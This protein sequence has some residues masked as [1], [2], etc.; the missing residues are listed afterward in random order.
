MLF[1]YKYANNSTVEST[2]RKTDMAFAPDVL[3]NPTFF[4][5]TLGKNI[6]FREAISA[7][8]DVVVSDLRWKAR[9][10]QNRED[11]KAYA[12]QKEEEYMQEMLLEQGNVKTEVLRVQS[13][14]AEVNRQWNDV[15]GPYYKAQNKWRSYVRKYERELLWVLDPVITVHPDEIFFE[16]FSQDESSYGRL[17]CSYE[18]F[19]KI[20]EF[21]C[22]TTNIDY[23]DALY[24]EF[25]KIREYKDTKFV[26]DP[27][28]FEVQ[29]QTEDTFKELKIDLPDSWVRGFL[30]VSSAMTLD[31]VEF[32]LHPMD[33]HNFCFIL[34]RNKEKRGPRSIKFLLKPNEPIKAI[35]EPWNIELKCSRSVY[36]GSEEKEIRIWGRRRLLILERLI[37]VAQ[38]FKVKLLGTGLPSFFIADLG[39]MNFTLGLSGWTKNDWSRAGNFDLMAPRADIDLFTKNKVFET[40]KET[41]HASAEE[42]SK[43]MNLDPALIRG[44]LSAYTQAGRVMY[45]M[46][47]DVYRVRELSREPLPYQ[48]LRFSNERE[49]QAHRYLDQNKVRLD[50]QEVRSERLELAGL[51]WEDGGKKFKTS[52]TID[53]DERLINANCTC[54]FFKKNKLYQGPCEHI[55]A[56]RLR[57]SLQQENIN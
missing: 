25:Q 29:T 21:G 40:L 33:I 13:D 50:R 54:Q 51:V 24:K 47:K 18:V 45:D 28:G 44:A 26:V 8:H 5:G 16:C 39:H 11:Y 14:I 17:G 49:E 38:K 52:L 23:S 34:K 1:N 7:L 46:N 32:D 57:H 15:M 4:R 27:S 41:W 35:F 56:T 3:R 36:H 43:K 31:A 42:L 6:A 9:A 53:A 37:P 19:K 55:L 20:D 48:Q 10:D 2:N 30:Q 22:G 12:A